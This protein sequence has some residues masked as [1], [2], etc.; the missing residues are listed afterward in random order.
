MLTPLHSCKIRGYNNVLKFEDILRVL[1]YKLQYWWNKE[2]R[3]WDCYY[4]H[5]SKIKNKEIEGIP[6]R[7]N[8]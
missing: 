3:L 6:G 7:V 5:W 4:S 2:D 8:G 1:D